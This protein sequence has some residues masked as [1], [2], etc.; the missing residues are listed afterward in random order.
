[1]AATIPDLLSAVPLPQAFPF[2]TVN[3]NGGYFQLGPG[4]TISKCDSR[5]KVVS[6]PA[7]RVTMTFGRESPSLAPFSPSIISTSKEFRS[8]SS[9]ISDAHLSYPIFETDSVLTST[10]FDRR[11]ISYSSEVNVYPLMCYLS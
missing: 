9:M 4:G 1:M 10:I 2:S 11:L 8:A 3:S 6:E 5:S 7:S